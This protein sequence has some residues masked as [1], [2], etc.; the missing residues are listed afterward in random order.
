MKKENKLINESLFEG[1]IESDFGTGETFTQ[2]KGEIL[3]LA[4]D[5]Q[6]NIF[7]AAKEV[8]SNAYDDFGFDKED[9]ERF[10]EWFLA[11]IAKWMLDARDVKVQI[12]LK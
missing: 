2:L 8:M 9:T 1:E 10:Y 3:S 5:D 6:Y 7:N 12:E 4:S 11:D